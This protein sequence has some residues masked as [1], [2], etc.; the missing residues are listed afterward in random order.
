[1]AQHTQLSGPGSSQRYASG[2]TPESSGTQTNKGRAG[3]IQP[4]ADRRALNVP[5]IVQPWNQPAFLALA[6]FEAG[7]LF[8]AFSLFSHFS[9]V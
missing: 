5:A 1:M 8:G 2:I 9:S 6:G 4:R 7:L 3:S